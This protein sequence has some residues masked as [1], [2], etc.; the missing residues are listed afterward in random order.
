MRACGA[1]AE[2]TWIT[3]AMYDAYLELHA[4]GWV[5]SVEVWQGARLV[6]GV[7]GIAIGSF[8]A[9]ESMFHRVRDASKVALAELVS[10]L[11]ARGYTLLDVQFQTPHLATLGVI[12][13]ARNLYLKRLRTAVA[14]PVLFPET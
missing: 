2:G 4:L 14:A 7:Y 12:E 8:F 5:H 13:V 9:A 6:G 10:R 11:A 1:R 3:D